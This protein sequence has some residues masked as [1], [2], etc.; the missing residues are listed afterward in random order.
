[1]IADGAIP[2]AH[3]QRPEPLRAVDYLDIVVGA[4]DNIERNSEN[5]KRRKRLQ[6]L[7]GK[8]G[9]NPRTPSGPRVHESRQ[10]E[11][12]PWIIDIFQRHKHK[13]VQ[14]RRP[15]CRWRPSSVAR[16]R[17]RS[18][19]AIMAGIV[20][21]EELRVACGVSRDGIKA[22]NVVKVARE[23]GLIA[24]GLQKRAGRTAGSFHCP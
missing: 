12:L 23:Y 11:Q 2:D 7:H 14:N 4:A 16:L 15:S 22:S 19:W 10:G 13:R 17:W 24:K 3:R 20:P 9:E 6:L 1:M 5:R 18:C 8:I 21:L